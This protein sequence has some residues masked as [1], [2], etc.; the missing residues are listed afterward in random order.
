MKMFQI[1]VEFNAF[2]E[3]ED[4]QRQCYKQLKCFWPK[5]R[6]SNDRENNFNQHIL[7]HLNKRQFVC[8]ECNKQFRINS[9][10][11][12]HKRYVHQKVRPFVGL[13]NDFNKRFQTKTHLMRHQSIHSSVKSF[14]C[15]KCDK[16]FKTSSE[17]KN[18]KKF[19]HSN[20]RPFFLS[21]K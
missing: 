15:D 2:D 3:N 1:S 14:T 12:R 13:L 20:I 18:H 7:Q 19:I 17:L 21:A 6:Y 9:N 8:E 5:C 4:K 16:R 11:L 10:L